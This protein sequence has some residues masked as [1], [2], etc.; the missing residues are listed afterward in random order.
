MAADV[1][2]IELSGLSASTELLD[3]SE[4]SGGVASSLLRLDDGVSPGVGDT[5]VALMEKTNQIL[6]A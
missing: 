3:E 1:R 5:T 2:V 6:Y 4:K